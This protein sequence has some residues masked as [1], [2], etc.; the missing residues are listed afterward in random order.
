[1]A[2]VTAEAATFDLGARLDAEIVDPMPAI[3]AAQNRSFSNSAVVV[4]VVARHR[5]RLNRRPESNTLGGWDRRLEEILRDGRS[6]LSRKL[7]GDKAVCLGTRDEKPCRRSSCLRCRRAHLGRSS[8]ALASAFAGTPWSHVFAVT[9]VLDVMPGLFGDFVGD[10]RPDPELSVPDSWE[11]LRRLVPRLSERVSRQKLDMR[12]RVEEVFSAA[13]VRAYRLVGRLE[14]AFHDLVAEPLLRAPRPG[15]RQVPNKHRTMAALAHARGLDLDACQAV[16]IPHVHAWV[17][18][19]GPAGPLSR[20]E[21]AALFH[22]A[23]SAPAQAMVKGMR[24][25]SGAD[26]VVKYLHYAG[27]FQTKYPDAEVL[28][29]VAE[30]AAVG[31]AAKTVRWGFGK[32]AMFPATRAVGAPRA[33]RPVVRPGPRR[34]AD[35][36]LRALRADGAARTWEDAMEMARRRRR[37]KRRLDRPPRP[38]TRP[39]APGW[40]QDSGRVAVLAGGSSVA[41]GLLG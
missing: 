2:A 19:D 35:P 10:L 22:R 23:F 21:V 36:A 12:R 13:G 39:D 31:R 40:P 15:F 33:V 5:A 17:A 20:D 27:K 8:R 26:Q 41:S 1:V 28:Q 29:L 38:G 34:L 25:P 11:D 24:G 32:S 16:A 9:V 30:D 3:G 7:H 6:P 4:P 18:V 14:Y 37:W